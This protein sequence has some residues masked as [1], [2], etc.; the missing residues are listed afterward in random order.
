MKENTSKSKLILKYLGIAFNVILIAIIAV[1]VYTMAA[2]LI[3]K[4]STVSI[5][6][7]T[8]AVVDTGSMEGD[9]PDSIPAK[10][11]IFLV[12]AKEYKIDDVVMFQSS[13]KTPV[14][15]RII[16][17]DDDG[18]ITKGDANNA[19]DTDRVKPDQIIGKVFL[20]VP[21][22]GYAIGWLKTP[23]GSMLLVLIC[24]LLIGAPIIF[25]SDEEKEEA[26]A[27][28]TAAAPDAGKERTENAS[29]APVTSDKDSADNEAK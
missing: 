11:I 7:I 15:H 24:F 14:T 17:V 4:K 10:S 9:K 16:G 20:T 13:G 12:R 25:R 5:F 3:T 27:P 18:F 23:L 2:R 6:G 29:A 26:D 8:N 22:V 28:A 19:A 1:N 21:Y